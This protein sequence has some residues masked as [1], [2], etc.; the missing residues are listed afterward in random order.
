MQEQSKGDFLCVEEVAAVRKQ[1]LKQRLTSKLSKRQQ[2]QKRKRHPKQQQQKHKQ[3]QLR[4]LEQKLS[5][6]T[7]QSKKPN[8]KQKLTKL[9]APQISAKIGLKS[10]DQFLQQVALLVALDHAVAAV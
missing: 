9:L 4:E 3:Q 6:S 5:S 1:Q 2:Q 8:A 7:K 10:L